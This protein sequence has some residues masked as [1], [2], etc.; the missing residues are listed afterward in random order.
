MAMAR[1]YYM[2]QWCNYIM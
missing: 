1:S 2:Y